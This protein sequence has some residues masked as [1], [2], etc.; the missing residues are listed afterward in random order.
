MI[1]QYG[2]LNKLGNFEINENVINY[3]N[4]L[5]FLQLL[6]SVIKSVIEIDKREVCF[7]IE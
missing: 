1:G 3:K 4:V 7:I 5:L 6:F 2:I